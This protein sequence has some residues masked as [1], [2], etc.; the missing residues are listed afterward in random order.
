[1]TVETAPAALDASSW[2]SCTAGCCCRGS[3]RRRCCACCARGGSRSGSP[4]SARRP[5]PSGGRRARGPTTGSCRCTGTSAC[6][7]AAGSTST[8]LLRQLLGRAGG[9][10]AG[11]DRSFHFGAL[12]HH[13]VGMISHLGAM[14]PVADG[15]A[16][17]A[18]L[19][20]EHRVAAALHGRRR[21]QR[22]RLP[23]GGEPGRGVEAA[24]ALR[25]REQPVRPVD[26]DS[27]A[28]RLRRPGRPRR[29]ATA[30]PG[31]VVRRQRRA[32][33][34]SAPC[35]RPR[36]AGAARRRPDAARVQDLP[37]AWARGGVGHRL[38]AAGA[39]ASL[40]RARPDQP[41][42]GR[43]RRRG[44]VLSPDDRGPPARASCKADI[45]ARVAAALEAPVPDVDGRGGDAATSSPRHARPGA[46]RPARAPAAGARD[47]LPRRHR[48]RPAR[49]ACGADPTGAAHGPGHRRVRRRLQGHRRVRRRVRP[50][51]RSQHA[52]HRVG[53]A[54]RAPSGSPS[55]D[56][57]PMVEM[58][59]GDFI[60]CGFNQIVNNL[61]KTHYRWGAA[62]PVVVRVPVGG[63]HGRRALPL[64]ERRGLVHPRRRASRSS[65]RRRRP[66]P[67]GCC[68]PR[69]TTATRCCILEHKFLYRNG[70]GTGAGGPPHG[71]D[72][73]G[74]RGAGGHAT[75]RSSPTASA[76]TGRS[77]RPTVLAD[78]GVE[79]EVV[80]LRS[81]LPWD[82]ETV[83]ASVRRTGRALVLHEAPVTGGFG[84]R[85][86]RDHRRGR[87]S[88]TST[89][90]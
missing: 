13:I 11:R 44:R 73:A 82:V 20:G 12:E 64:P 51:P 90:R 52:D 46:P 87:R 19:R 33:G 62:V 22:G 60:S 31:V 35:A 45:D 15:L 76:C 47:A 69:S 78:E 67:R 6:S 77:R 59:F 18:Q 86:G 7:P 65:P 39:D 79:V 56:S 5:S 53:R 88:V 27:R 34:A 81:L 30:C 32:R 63:G 74:R 17:A 54:R 66:T 21:H 61:A 4:A 10:T 23:R 14:L 55:T 58:Q 48:R 1:M 16:L 38:R 3:S 26:A 42:R 24:G 75:P 57:C 25:R 72:R 80:D 89:R 37:H 43:A 36:A 9:Y 28:V 50:G 68:S 29:S 70:R 40:G 8:A 84:R 71:A 85:G 49:G 2:W 83:L 41:L